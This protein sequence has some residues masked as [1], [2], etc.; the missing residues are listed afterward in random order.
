MSKYQL[1]FSF[2]S[3]SGVCFWT[4]NEAAFQRFE[5]YTVYVED[6]PLTPATNQALGE[7]IS[8]YDQSLIWDYPDTPGRWGKNE[9]L[10]FDARVRQLLPVVRQ[11]LGP[12]FEI[13]DKH[14]YTRSR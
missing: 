2:D 4:A 5:D 6:L 14:Q 3:Y 11:E 8:R 7:L 12:D 9:W 10:A 13:I 1:R